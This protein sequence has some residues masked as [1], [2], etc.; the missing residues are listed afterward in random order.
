MS[1]LSPEAQQALVQ[2]GM[3]LAE[4]T[5]DFVLGLIRTAGLDAAAQKAHIAELKLRLAKRADAVEAAPEFDPD[6][7]PDPTPTAPV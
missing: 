2:G 5:F 7:T 1:G 3:A 6:A 4:N